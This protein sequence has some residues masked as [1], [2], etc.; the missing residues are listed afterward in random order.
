MTRG[1]LTLNERIGAL[2]GDGEA[3]SDDG[4]DIV[5]ATRRN[6]IRPSEAGGGKTKNCHRN[7]LEF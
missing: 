5:E 1:T 3:S 4:L 7:F 2:D 6:L